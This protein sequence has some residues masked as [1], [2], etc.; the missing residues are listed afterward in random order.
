MSERFQDYAISYLVIVGLIC[1]V[2]SCSSRSNEQSPADN[3]RSTAEY[4]AQ[5][6]QDYAQR[7]DLVRVRQGIILLEEALTTEPGNYD[8][9]WRISKFDYYLG[10]HTDI[11]AERDKAFSDGVDAGKIAVK[12]QDGKPDGHFW[13]GANYGGRA[14]SSLLAGLASVDDIRNEMETVLRLD[15][16][17]Q[18]G[19]AYM[20]LG[21]VNLQA[22]KLIGGDPQKA[23]DEMEKGLRFGKTNALLHLHLAEAYLRVGRTAD[24]RRQ[25]NE[26]LSMTPDQGYLPEYKEAVSKAQK[27][28][29]KTG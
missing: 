25:L 27:L 8:A 2:S 18:S 17:Y 13:L 19:S 9:A 23:V 15:E 10:T 16:G 7:D 5:A 22:P 20:V 14:Q 1:A 26:I 24:A 29:P 11:N 21:L 28:L 4:I 6:D 12:L 3:T